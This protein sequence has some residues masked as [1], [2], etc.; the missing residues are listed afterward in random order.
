MS[1]PVTVPLSKPIEHDGKTHA[2]LTFREATVGDMCAAD[3]VQGDFHKMVAVLAGMA[4]VSMPM[5][6][7]LPARD[8]T[9]ITEAV[10]HLMGESSAAT[11]STSSL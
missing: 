8:F 3:L 4:D 1:E 2:S 10:G 5:M 7:L 6:K 9:R 11:G